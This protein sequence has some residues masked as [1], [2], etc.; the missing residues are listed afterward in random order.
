MLP[1]TATKQFTGLIGRVCSATYTSKHLATGHSLVHSRS[2]R[3]WAL[4]RDQNCKAVP[5]L[6]RHRSTV[7]PQMHRTHHNTRSLRPLMPSTP[8]VDV[9]RT[10]Y[11]RQDRHDHNLHTC[12]VHPR[13]S[14]TSLYASAYTAYQPTTVAWI[15]R[16]AHALHV[17]AVSSTPPEVCP[18][19]TALP[20]QA[21]LTKP[22][23]R[24]PLKGNHSP[25]V[26]RPALTHVCSWHTHAVLSVARTGTRC[27]LRCNPCPPR[28]AFT[29]PWGHARCP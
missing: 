29:V 25:Y 18:P 24:R 26:A 21:T 27:A 13:R 17:G 16:T 4:G 7:A 9:A 8:A 5:A 23:R 2:G 1:Q 6:S 15:L 11:F 20:H 19:H 14:H 28:A 10:R 22:T 12:S 3:G